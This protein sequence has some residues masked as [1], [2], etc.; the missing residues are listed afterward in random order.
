MGMP[1]KE[2]A[3]GRNWVTGAWKPMSGKQKWV[4]AV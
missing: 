1:E 4:R 3:A 2:D